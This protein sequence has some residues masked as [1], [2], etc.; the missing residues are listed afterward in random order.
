MKRQK[1]ER[2]AD[3]QDICELSRII[4]KISDILS[5]TQKLPSSV[6]ML[7]ESLEGKKG[8]YVA[9]VEACE[10]R[11]VSLKDSVDVFHKSGEDGVKMNR[12]SRASLKSIVHVNESEGIKSQL[13]IA[14]NK[15]E[16]LT[17][18]IE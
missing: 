7:K 14:K 5:R 10:R 16:G 13:E 12:S 17:L 4:L 15:I 3:A 18:E 6:L 1:S 9:K 11:I 2:V 8:S